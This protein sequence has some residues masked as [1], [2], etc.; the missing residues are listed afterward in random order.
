[1]DRRILAVTP[2]DVPG[3]AEQTLLRLL[4]GLRARG[5]E[6]TLTTPGE[7]SL[8][9]RAL[10]DGH[11]WEP[12]PLGGLGRGE[13][14]R[15][16][17]SWPRARAL[18]AKHDVVYLNHTVC[19]RLLPALGPGPRRVLHVHDMVRRVPQIWR[20]ADLV[21]ADSR[22]VAELLRPLDAVVVYGP[23]DPDPP[24]AAAPWPNGGG[25]VIGF[26]GRIEPRKGVLDLVAAVPAIRAGAPGARVVVVGSDPYGSDPAYLAAVD[27]AEGIE[28]YAWVETG[29]LRH[30]DVLVLPSYQEP[31]GTVL[32]DAMA[33]G[34]PVVASAVD[35]L[36]EV[37]ED[38]VTGALV[39]P[40]DPAALAAGVLRVL[41]QRERMG[42]A[43]RLSAARF[44]TDRYVDRL[45]ALLVGA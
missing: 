6:T 27:G 14:A 32:S 43:A 10:A 20:R 36:L 16:V 1:M 18:A 22:A 23:V 29:A 19:G 38:G 39:P 44:H 21:L 37:V 8:R 31:F 2:V 17:T 40:G 13:G 7:G 5:W 33:V 11:A 30:L 41:G 34:T 26:V 42:E 35:G 9:D 28:R 12:L 4:R 25:P 15:A 45:E 24:P 3:G